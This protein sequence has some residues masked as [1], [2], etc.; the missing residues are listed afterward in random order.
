MHAPCGGI[1][2]ADGCPKF[3]NLR[4]PCIERLNREKV[5]VG[6]LQV[7]GEF[8]KLHRLPRSGAIR[9]VGENARLLVVDEVVVLVLRLLADRE[10]GLVQLAGFADLLED[11]V[12]ELQGVILTEKSLMVS[13]FTVRSVVDV[14][15]LVVNT[16]ASCP[17]CHT[18][19]HCRSRR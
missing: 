10:V 2:K 3:C 16:N 4:H 11:G 5:C 12:V 6:Q 17:C 18:A 14:P 15:S 8:G 7:L 13:R 19:C 9:I 1:R